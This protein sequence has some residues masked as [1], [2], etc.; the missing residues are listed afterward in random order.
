MCGIVAVA[1]N[2]PDNIPDVSQSLSSMN[3]RGPDGEGEW[4]SPSGKTKLG[5]RRLAIV[6]LSDA[7][8]Q[9]MHNENKTIW[10]VCN[11]EIY[12]CPNLRTRLEGLGHFFYS[13]SDNEVILHAYEEW[14]EDCLKHLEGMFAFTLWDNN[15]ESLFAA[16]DRVGI[17]PLCYSEIPGGIALASDFAALLPLLPRKPDLNP[18]AISYAMTLRY[19]PSPISIWKG[20]HKLEPGYRLSW[21][22]K[23]G[24]RIT[25]YWSPPKEIDYSGNYSP[26]KWEELFHTVL[27]DHLLSDVPIGLFLSGGLDSSSIAAGVC[28][29]GYRPKALTVSFPEYA[30]NEAPVAEATVKQLCLNHEIINI[31]VNDIDKLLNKIFHVYDEPHGNLGLIPMYLICQAASK[32]FKTILA[33]DGGDECFGGYAWHRKRLNRVPGFISPLNRL[34]KKHIGWTKSSRLNQRLSKLYYS[35]F[36][37]IQDYS[38]ETAIK[39]L[40]EEMEQLMAPS[41]LCFDDNKRAEPLEKYFVKS[42][43]LMRALQRVDLMTFCSELVLPKVDRASMGHSLEVRV[44][45]LD[46]RIIEWALRSPIKPMESNLSNSKPV[47]R[48]YLKSRK[49]YDTLNNPKQGFSL[50][51]AGNYP[52]DV[53]IEH[54]KQSWLVKSGFWHKK[55]EKII[56]S[57]TPDKFNRIWSSLMLAKWSDR[58]M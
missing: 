30:S 32:H 51:I 38:W 15:I 24:L 3:R 13:G 7:G 16:R 31:K 18:E 23:A 10:L 14:G 55:W 42:L 20:T 11:G 46:R 56:T 33:G 47:L 36:S 2:S 34:L 45:F 26:E 21:N 19:I 1:T 37:L 6:D 48:R 35:K 27:K 22:E 54:I 39:F 57:N 44:P 58:W 40:P 5:H 17:K 49:M 41:G 50:K 8:R 29:I 52:Q 4:A 28:D 12:N 53:A 43:P 9:P 25:K